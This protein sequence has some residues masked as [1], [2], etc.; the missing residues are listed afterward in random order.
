MRL[1]DGATQEIEEIRAGERVLARNAETGENVCREVTRR[2]V[3]PG[4]RILELRVGSGGGATQTLGVTGDHPFWRR[5]D[6]WTD[7]ARL[8]PGDEV[9]TSAGGWVRV[10]GSS[11]RSGRQTVYN[12]EVAGAHTYFV[13][14]PALWVH[15][16]CHGVEKVAERQ[17]IPKNS[18]TTNQ[19]EVF[20]HLEKHTEIPTHKLSRKLHELKKAG[21]FNPDTDMVF[22]RSGSVF[23]PKT[24]EHVGELTVD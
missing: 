15:N 2:M 11:W 22:D 20:G 7:A 5:S 18:L 8:E 17:G 3:T 16:S 14:D 1:C 24:G 10:A 13:G 9:Y 23:N 21:G 12:L 6:G 19:E 4:A